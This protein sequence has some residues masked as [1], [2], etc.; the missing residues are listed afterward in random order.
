M[1]AHRCDLEA[2][3]AGASWGGQLPRLCE[4]YVENHQVKM[5]IGVAGR[6]RELP[7]G[8]ERPGADWRDQIRNENTNRYH[9]P[10]SGQGPKFFR[11]AVGIF[12]MPDGTSAPSSG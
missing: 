1:G 12:E 7:R 10:F 5:D 3:S 9:E 2:C 8:R 11:P 6:I 4:N